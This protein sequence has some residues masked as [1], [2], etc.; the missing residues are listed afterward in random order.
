MFF[1]GRVDDILQGLR[2][3]MWEM[4]TLSYPIKE[5]DINKHPEILDLLIAQLTPKQRKYFDTQFEYRY[6][7]K[8]SEYEDLTEL[9]KD[10]TID[11]LSDMGIVKKGEGV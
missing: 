5:V 10:L 3:P 2:E 8:F 6:F 4:Q 7:F 11:I 1:G 9:K